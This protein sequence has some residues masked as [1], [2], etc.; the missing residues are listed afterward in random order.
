MHSHVWE[1]TGSAYH[2]TTYYIPGS[3]GRVL[4]LSPE[5][6]ATLTPDMTPRLTNLWKLSEIAEV[7]P[8]PLA[9]EPSPDLAALASHPLT[10]LPP[11][12]LTP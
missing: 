2:G 12:P 10:P 8:A 11:Y 3:Y 1:R 9:A 5:G 7:A 4:R 6:L